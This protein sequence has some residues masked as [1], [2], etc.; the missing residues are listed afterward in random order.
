MRVAVF[1]V[2]DLPAAARRLAGFF[3]KSCFY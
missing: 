2:V 3:I 1:A